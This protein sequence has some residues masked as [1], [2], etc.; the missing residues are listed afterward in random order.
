V[1][2]DGECGLCNRFVVWL[3]RR[4]RRRVLHFAPLRGELAAAHLPPLAESDREWTVA[5]WD[6]DGIHV[7]SDAALRAVASV[8]SIWRA[9]R[10]LLLLPRFLRN[11]VY[12]VIARNRIRW[13]G[14]VDSCA[15]LP[16]ERRDRL[17]D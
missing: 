17:L 4:D 12:R 16:P 13:F 6:A 3:L 1:F 8:G 2:F 5:L 15:L 7:E 11:P 9:A 10:L 14:R